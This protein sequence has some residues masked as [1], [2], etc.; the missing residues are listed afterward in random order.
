MANELKVMN[1]QVMGHAL[2]LFPSSFFLDAI[3]V[4]R[5]CAKHVTHT[6]AHR[7][8]AGVAFISG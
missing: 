5:I 1:L 4:V 2:S 8:M 3:R 7:Q 6:L